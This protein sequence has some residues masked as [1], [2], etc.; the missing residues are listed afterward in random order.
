MTRLTVNERQY[1]VELSGSGVPIVLLHGFTGDTTIWNGVRHSLEQPYQVI[2][3]DILGHGKSGKPIDVTTYHMET[4]ACDLIKLIEILSIGKVHLLG[5]SMGGRL[6][7]YLAIHY[8]DQFLSLILE[9][10]S[11]GLKSEQERVERR[12]RDNVLADKIETNGIEWFV[13][14]WESLSLW[15]SQQSLPHDI[16]Q[17]QRAQRLQNSSHG[18]ANSLRGMG[19]G[20]QPNLWGDLENLMLPTQLIVGEH[21]SK[22]MGI[23][24]EMATHIPNVM[25]T[26]VDGAG[27]TVHL[28]NSK[29]FIEQVQL[30]LQRF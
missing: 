21:D 19:T 6:A 1:N 2:A 18:L 9:S 26:T 4:M 28:E 23:N 8:P 10:A 14:F 13:D 16:L 24:H 3:I 7:L 22:F 20:T 29:A 27:H 12:D 5:Y 17:I 11:P 25:M 15:D 30:F